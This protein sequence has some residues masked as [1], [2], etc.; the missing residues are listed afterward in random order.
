M[1]AA[2]GTGHDPFAARGFGGRASGIG[3]GVQD[4]VRLGATR[5]EI[6]R[7][8]TEQ[9]RFSHVASIFKAAAGAQAS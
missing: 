1:A 5:D 6:R 4:F 7:A 2:V 3:N 9:Q 8:P